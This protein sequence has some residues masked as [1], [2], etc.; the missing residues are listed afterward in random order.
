VVQP[1]VYVG[2][3]AK[4]GENCL[5]MA[6]SVVMDGCEL[7]DRVVLNPGAIVGGEGFGFAPTPQGLLKIPQVGKAVLESDVEIGANSCVDRAAMGETRVG[8]GSK[9]DNLVQI[10]HAARMGPHCT[11]VALSGIAGSAQVG[12]G[13]T[14]A[15]GAKVLGHFP[16]GDGTQVGAMS[17]LTGETPKGAQRSGVPAI[18]H[19]EWLKLAA[20]L[21]RL[22]E[23]LE[24]VRSLEAQVA[25]LRPERSD[26]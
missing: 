22:S 20:A 2:A 7:G 17:L 9:I 26:T 4:I 14:V 24:R 18:E 25:S 8:H 13:V 21:P 3:G 19:G 15:A 6:N 1:F 5:L 16:V 12:K 10:G 11:V 23:L